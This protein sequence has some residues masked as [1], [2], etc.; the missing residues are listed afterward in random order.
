MILLDTNVVIYLCVRPARLTRLASQAIRR[1][2]AKS[3]LAVAAPTLWEL[4]QAVSTGRVV[5]QG[6]TDGF[7]RECLDVCS[8][9]VLP[10]TLDIAVA[11]AHLPS[12][13]PKDPMDRLIAATAR[14]HNL[15]LVT[16]DESI[17]ASGVVRVV[18]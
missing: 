17:R 6:S 1:G 13:F 11:A 14:V 16:S 10:L 9:E 12:T 18:W 15:A 2:L 3:Y 7:V 4:A 8:A 5:Y